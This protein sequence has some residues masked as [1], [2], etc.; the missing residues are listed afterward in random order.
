VPEDKIDITHILA[1]I[2]N[3]IGIDDF[4]K[5]KDDIS[6]RKIIQKSI[7]IL[8]LK[9]FDFNLGYRYNLYLA[10]PYSPDLSEDYYNIVENSSYYNNFVN[11]LKFDEKTEAALDRF[12]Q[13]FSGNYALV[14]CF[15][16]IH[17]LKTYSFSYCA[18][19]IKSE[20]VMK[21]FFKIK[22]QYKD[23]PEIV[24]QATALF[25]SIQS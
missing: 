19:Y 1:L 25:D 8:Q 3:R 18:D 14:E 6:Y 24:D 20:E 12:N 11:H 21:Y 2:L 9:E 15:A 4:N 17:F 22:P 10:G 13:I 23:Q 5:I 7:Y 16:T